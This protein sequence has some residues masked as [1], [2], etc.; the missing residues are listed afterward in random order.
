M[1]LRKVTAVAALFFLFCFSASAHHTSHASRP[2]YGGG[3]HTTSH[4]GRYQG[5]TN[6]HH[7]GGHYRNPKSNNQYGRHK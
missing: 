1:K 5:E 2:Y 6:V 3:H 4:G 7:K